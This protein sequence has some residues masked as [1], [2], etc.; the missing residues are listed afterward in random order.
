[1]QK[2]DCGKC[3]LNRGIY[4]K[5]DID[6]PSLACVHRA[7]VKDKVF[8]IFAVIENRKESYYQPHKL[9]EQYSSLAVLKND[10]SNILELVEK[11]TYWISKL[12]LYL[13]IF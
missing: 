4:D 5:I 11:G 3:Y 12:A 1:M 9:M 2:Y 10:S 6:Y 13:N 8:V 7:L